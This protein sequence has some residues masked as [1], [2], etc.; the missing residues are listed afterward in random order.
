MNDQEVIDAPFEDMEVADLTELELH[1]QEEV[2]MEEAPPGEATADDPVEFIELVPSRT[3]DSSSAFVCKYCSKKCRKEE[4]LEAHERQHEGKKVG[5]SRP[6]RLGKTKL[7]WRE[8][9]STFL[10]L[11]FQPYVCKICDQE[12]NSRLP[13]RS[14]MIKHSN[15]TFDCPDCDKTF[16][17]PQLLGEHRKRIHTTPTKFFPCDKCGKEFT[18]Q[19]TRDTH[20]LTHTDHRPVQCPKCSMRFKSEFYLKMHEVRHSET[21]N[22]VCPEE[23]CGKAFYTKSELNLHRRGVHSDNKEHPCKVC[24]KSFI[25][26][27]QLVTHNKKAHSKENKKFKCENC[28]REFD[29]S[30]KLHTHMAKEHS[31][32]KF[33]CEKCKKVFRLKHS[34][35]VHMKNH[36]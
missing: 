6:W 28:P 27:S 1:L 11:F 8:Q 10:F 22:F 21:K 18:R 29:S 3:D 32:V 12:F 35:A 26:L 31:K 4:T 2:K 20:M 17:Y 19:Q 5:S 36:K 24:S 14:H 25:K 16:A 7:K 15:K 30:Q 33:E 13:L 34:L 9:I 23:E